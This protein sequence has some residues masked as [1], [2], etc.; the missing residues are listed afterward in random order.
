MTITKATYDMLYELLDNHTK[1][2]LIE[3][4]IDELFKNNEKE[5]FDFIREYHDIPDKVSDDELR[6]FIENGTVIKAY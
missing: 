2:E 4:I 1:E 6:D 5:A 3:T